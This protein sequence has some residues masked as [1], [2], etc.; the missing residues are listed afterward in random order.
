MGRAGAMWLV[1][2][3]MLLGMA[4]VV[5]G[6]KDKGEQLYDELQCGGCHDPVRDRMEIGMGPGLVTI[7]ATYAGKHQ[8]LVD[9]LQSKRDPQV[10]P[11]HFMI[12]ELQ[13]F[14]LLADKSDA[15]LSALADYLLA[16]Q[17]PAAGE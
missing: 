3:A 16:Y 15:E 9:F 8:N 1:L 7:A 11:E 14:T 4:G 17:R 6:E 5:A 2:A 12:M 13:L 10:S